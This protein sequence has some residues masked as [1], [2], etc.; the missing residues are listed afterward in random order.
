MD[1]ICAVS[2]RPRSPSTDEK[3]ARAAI[4][5]VIFQGSD[6]SSEARAGKS[7]QEILEQT[8]R[9]FRDLP[10]AEYPN[11]T[12]LADG[13]TIP[14]REGRFLFGLDRLIAGIAELAGS[15]PP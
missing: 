10:A 13:L 9:L 5:F 1:F 11:V 2:I 7:R 8:R 6:L 12:A 3:S 4:G 14:D 15:P